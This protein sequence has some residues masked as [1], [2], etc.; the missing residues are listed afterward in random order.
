M[1]DTSRQAGK[2]APP[3]G[4]GGLQFYYPRGG[5]KDCCLLILWVDLRLTS[6][7][8][9]SYWVRVYLSLW[10]QTRTVTALIQISR[11]VVTDARICWITS[12]VHK[13]RVSGCGMS[14][15]PYFL[16]LVLGIIILLNLDTGLIFFFS[17]SRWCE[18]YWMLCRD[19][20]LLQ[21][22]NLVYWL[23]EFH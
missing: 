12:G 23:E 16:S 22:D 18:L 3:Q 2:E 13:I 19:K 20:I 7:A 5:R 15:F 9:P 10:G 17:R 11:R 1:R 21:W 4:W 14:S 8:P 6:L